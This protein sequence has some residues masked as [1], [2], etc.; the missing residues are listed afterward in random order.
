MKPLLIITYYFPPSGG[1]GVQRWLKFIKYLPLHGYEPVV[2]TVDERYASYPQIDESLNA[3]VPDSIRV[4]RT[5]S[6]EVLKLYRHLS[7]SGQLPHTGF[8]NEKEPNLLQKISRFIRGNFFLPDPRKGWNRYAL[9][10]ASKLIEEEGIDTVITT[11]PPHSTQLIGLELKRRFPRI[12][13]VA[14]LRDPWSDIYYNKDLY[15]TSMARN[16]NQKY[17]REVLETADA[18]ITVS[19]EC[20]QNFRSKTKMELPISVIPNGYDPDDFTLVGNN[21]DTFNN[22][23]IV[24]A[25]FTLSYVGALSPLYD[26]ETIL[27]AIKNLPKELK[28]Y[29]KIRFVGGAHTSAKESFDALGVETEW[30][31]YVTHKEAVNYM[32]NTDMLL[33]LLPNQSENKGIVTGKIFEYMASSNPVLAVCFSDGDAARILSQYEN[34][35]IFTFGQFREITEFLSNCIMAKRDRISPGAIPATNPLYAQNFTRKSLT[36][37]LV[38]IL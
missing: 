2:M 20:V 25:K 35:G 13:W 36:Q 18:I 32:I 3:D 8:A 4:I 37:R 34:G 30:V 12:K 11:S 7:P 15:Q 28:S 6:C 1:A 26:T 24:N 21:S 23:D 27:K 33:L 29:L 9:K 19:G 38:E 14:D 5:K 10:V 31:G 22:S 17:E 16:R